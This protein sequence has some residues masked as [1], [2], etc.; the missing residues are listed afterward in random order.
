MVEVGTA[1]LSAVH[2][3]ETADRILALDAVHSGGTPGTVYL[4][5]PH[6][7]KRDRPWTSV[8]ELG[9]L[10]T[11]GLM[12]PDA[13]PQLKVIGVEPEVIDYGLGT[14][15]PPSHAVLIASSPKRGTSSRSGSNSQAADGAPRPVRGGNT[16]GADAS[17]RQR[18]SSSSASGFA[19]ATILACTSGGTRS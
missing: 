12:A 8:H 7:E 15:P 19:A 11:L 3:L 2:L 6:G 18:Q 9:I 10:N 16:S 13:R 5:D 17:T 14:L 1:I 4:F